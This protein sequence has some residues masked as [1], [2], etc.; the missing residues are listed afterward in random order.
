[1]TLLG[2]ASSIQK[3]LSESSVLSN[4]HRSVLPTKLWCAFRRI[5]ERRTQPQRLLEIFEAFR[6][7]KGA[8]RWDPR[9]RQLDEITFM[10]LLCRDLGCCMQNCCTA[11]RII[12]CVRG[13]EVELGRCSHDH[14]TS[15]AVGLQHSTFVKPF[16]HYYG[17]THMIAPTNGR[18]LTH[19]GRI[20]G[21]SNYVKTIR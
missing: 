4:L 7:E 18:A 2:F 1:M 15:C 20:V 9:R 14:N 21:G 16:R 6:V 5:A 19:C 12:V 13:V 8:L 17:F 3:W 10:A 11:C